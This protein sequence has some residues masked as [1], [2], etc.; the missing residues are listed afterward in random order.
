MILPIKVLE[1]AIKARQKEID[2]LEKQMDETHRPTKDIL[3]TKTVRPNGNIQKS[4]YI[5]LER[6]LL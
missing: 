2:K 4:S 5:Y 3:I 1:E 6:Q